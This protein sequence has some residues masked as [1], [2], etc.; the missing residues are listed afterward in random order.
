[1]KFFLTIALAAIFTLTGN[2]AELTPAE[3]LMH[4]TIKIFNEKSTATG[5]F[6]QDDAPGAT[7]TNLILVTANHVFTTAKGDHVLLVCR[8]KDDNGKWQR[9]DHKLPIRQDKKEL[10]TRH[11]QQ[12]I[13][14]IRCQVP[15]N[16]IFEA[17]PRGALADEAHAKRVGL[18]I[19]TQL[20][21]CTYPYR[22]E[23]SAAGF[24]LLRT[25]IVSGYP[26][27]PVADYPTVFHTSP[28][29]SGDS[30]APIAM[31]SNDEPYPFAIVG[32]VI[33]RTQQVDHLK[34][35]GWDVTF[36]R[37]INLGSF[38]HAAFVLET[39]DALAH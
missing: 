3:R 33:T 9:L 23:A 20:F 16:A 28:A 35:D 13:A 17:L 7:T 32:L 4:A 5:F 37:D 10:W 11:H 1:M 26:L 29:C 2:T 24:P 36:K 21:F 18:S 25:A 12:D 31:L 39:L 30:G 6:L 19:G 34:T 27:F 15:P 14:V 38:T 22:T 8:V